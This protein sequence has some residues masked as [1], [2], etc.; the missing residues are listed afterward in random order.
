MNIKLLTEHYLEF[1]SLKGGCTG[2]SESTLVEIQHSWKSR[3]SAHISEFN[4]TRTKTYPSLSFFFLLFF[5]INNRVDSSFIC[6]QSCSITLRYQLFLTSQTLIQPLLL[7]FLRASQYL[8]QYWKSIETKIS[9]T[10]RKPGLEV[11]K[12]EFILKLKIKRN[13]WLLADTCL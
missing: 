7:R 2:S 4:K 9:N 5:I 1:L 3:V 11:I 6:V 10:T 13:D 8:I 12:L